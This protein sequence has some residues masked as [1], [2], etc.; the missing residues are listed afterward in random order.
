MTSASPIL[1]A[2]A[3]ILA[4]I[5][6]AAPTP[7]NSPASSGLS[8]FRT[9][10]D[11][12][13]VWANRSGQILSVLSITNRL[14]QDEILNLSDPVSVRHGLTNYSDGMCGFGAR[15]SRT[16]YGSGSHASVSFQWD[17]PRP[18]TVFSFFGP[19]ADA[20]SAWQVE[21]ITELS[22]KV[23]PRN[24][25][26]HPRTN[27]PPAAVRPATPRTNTTRSAT[28]QRRAVPR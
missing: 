27:V 18:R 23:G 3:L 17:G 4:S 28:G 10:E 16:Y 12:R 5:L 15:L 8:T 26:E 9:T 1:T 25:I 24:V 14:S 21:M 6:S 20:A 7:A 2:T 19:D 13:L 11:L 22:N